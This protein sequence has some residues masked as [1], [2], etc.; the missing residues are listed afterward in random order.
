MVVDQL[1]NQPAVH[2]F[3]GAFPRRPIVQG[4][5]DRLPR[6]RSR[7]GAHGPDRQPLSG[8]ASAPEWL[9]RG[10]GALGQDLAPGAT[11]SL[12]RSAAYVDGAGAGRSVVVLACWIV[13]GLVLV[14]LGARRSAQASAA[15]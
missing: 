13:A 10:W 11:G 8:L 9:P 15:A 5:F 6:H 4:P 14:S 7:G 3:D 12:L 1:R 2:H